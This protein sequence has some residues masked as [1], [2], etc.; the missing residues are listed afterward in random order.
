MMFKGVGEVI[1]L[2]NQP[3]RPVII[4]GPSPSYPTTPS[5]QHLVELNTIGAGSQIGDLPA[6]HART[7]SEAGC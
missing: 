1:A 5:N 7:S 6:G 3:E 2:K 4:C